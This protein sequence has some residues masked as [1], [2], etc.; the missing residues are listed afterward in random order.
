MVTETRVFVTQAVKKPGVTDRGG[1]STGHLYA[2]DK[3]TGE[4]LLRLELPKTPGGGPMTYVA[5][6]RQH[7]VVPIGSRGEEHELVAYALPADGP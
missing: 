1:P 3:E 7:V 6:G 4:Q 2:F 5:G